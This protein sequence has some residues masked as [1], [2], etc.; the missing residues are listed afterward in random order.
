MSTSALKSHVT[1]VFLDP[2]FPQR[3]KNFGTFAYRFRISLLNIFTDFSGPFG[4]KWQYFEGG[5]IW[6][7][8]C[9]T[10]PNVITFGGSY[11]CGNFG[12]NRSRNV[13]VR[14]PTDGY[15]H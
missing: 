6:E 1:I 14:A 3:C 11:V 2:D 7:G 15:T 13:T 8:W 10:D 4:I 9:N 12:E 5:N